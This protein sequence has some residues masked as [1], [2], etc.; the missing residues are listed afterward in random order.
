M[1]LAE[2]VTVA[3]VLP[4][5][6]SRLRL[7]LTFP[8]CWVIPPPLVLAIPAP[9]A[10]LTVAVAVLPLIVLLSIVVCPSL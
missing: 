1:P 6:V 7:K 10:S 5:M 3:A 8:P 2:L 4:L 9:S